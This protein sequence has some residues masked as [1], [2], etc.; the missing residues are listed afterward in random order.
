VPTSTLEPQTAAYTPVFETVD[1]WFQMPETQP[2][3]CGY[4][5]V[6]EDRGDPDS[7]DIRLA[8]AILRHPDG[9]PE[10]DPMIR[11][12]GGPGGGYVRFMEVAYQDDATLFP[13]NRDV[14]AFDQRG[15]GLSEP[16]LECPEYANAMLDIQDYE[17]GGAQLTN[18]GYFDC[19]PSAIMGHIGV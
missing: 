6:P 12:H 3:D 19:R 13:T 1:C 4:L 8:V 2:V 14:I 16:A 10:P 5:I 7:L 18:D 11:L 17:V 15:V 9:S